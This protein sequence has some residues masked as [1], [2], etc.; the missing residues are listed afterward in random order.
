MSELNLIPNELKIKRENTLK[1]KKYVAIG[2]IIFAVFFA[3]IYIP[4]LYLSKLISEENSH[5]VKINSNSKVLI[6]NTKI[7]S[8]IKKYDIYIKDVDTLKKQRVK[9]TDKIINLQKYIPLDVFLTNIDYSNG[10]LS[11]SGTSANYRSICTFVANLQMSKEYPMARI[12]SIIDKNG[13][14]QAMVL[15]AKYEFTINI[16]EVK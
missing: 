1:L 16:I 7:L 11:L 2:I 6:E 10:V 14:G 13:N 8:E 3:I 4:K 5:T 12:A 9:I 15:P